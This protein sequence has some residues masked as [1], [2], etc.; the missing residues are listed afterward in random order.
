M[1]S[2]R[3]QPFIPRWTTG[4]RSV[5]TLLIVVSVMAFIAQS[6][7]EVAAPGFVK[8]WL[9]LSAAG[10]Q[11]GYY[12]Q[13]VSYLFIHGVPGASVAIAWARTCSSESG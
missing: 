4:R 9:C 1:G 2:P 11:Y 8:Q 7:A 12:W 10:I 13:F 3:I 6:F 5:V